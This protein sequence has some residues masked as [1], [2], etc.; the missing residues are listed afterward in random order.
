M[1]DALC[2]YCREA[3]ALLGDARPWRGVCD[4]S[5]TEQDALS[6]ELRA[7]LPR[8]RA[9]VMTRAQLTLL[10]DEWRVTASLPADGILEQIL[11]APF[12]PDDWCDALP[13]HI[14]RHAADEA[15]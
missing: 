10:R 1:D 15:A 14:R 3:R 12:D 4:L 5:P 9:S 7:V 11:A 6:A 8:V 13:P 2:T